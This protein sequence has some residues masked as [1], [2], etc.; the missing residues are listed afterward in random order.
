MQQDLADRILADRKRSSRPTGEWRRL[1]PKDSA[2][3]F[4][5][6]HYS[7]HDGPGIRTIVFLKG[8]PLR[9]PWCSNPES[10]RFGPEVSFVPN[11][12]IASMGCNRCALACPSAVRV[13]GAGTA[14]TGATAKTAD[15]STGATKDSHAT[16][17][18]SAGAGAITTTTPNEAPIILD[19]DA[20]DTLDADQLARLAKSCPSKALTL[21]GR[22]MSV[23]EVL[24]VVQRDEVFFD[25]SGG[26]LTVSGGEPLTHRTYL[27]ALLAGAHERGITTAIETC[28]YA[29]Y[30]S[31]AAAAEH[32]DSI[33]FDIKSM[34]SAKHRAWTGFGNERILSNFA[35]LCADHPELPKL[36]RTPV[37][38]GFNDSRAD[39]AAIIDFL[40][41]LGGR[42]A[43]ISYQPLRYHRFGE[44]K[45]RALG[46]EYPMGDMKLADGLFEQIRDDVLAS[47]LA[48]DALRQDDAADEDDGD[49]D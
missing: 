12:C 33:L 23:D 2:L 44:G 41:S 22:P 47:G 11:D 17:N 32:L 28:G 48:A 18:P 39:I 30:A 25:R 42:D 46:R 1:T 37:I 13:A 10:Q 7:L 34:D 15:T 8:C 16:T 6:Q 40:R 49:W 9:C 4:N 38:P 24:D 31:L 14:G 35:R 5:I 26:G 19:R 20:L 27:P 36:V 45:Y 43:N 21:E 29:P 3:V